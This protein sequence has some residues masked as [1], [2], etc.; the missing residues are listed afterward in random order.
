MIP[1]KETELY[2]VGTIYR[3]KKILI[4]LPDGGRAVMKHKTL[5]VIFE[6]KRTKDKVEFRLTGKGNYYIKHMLLKEEQ[7]HEADV[8]EEFE[9]LVGKG[10]D[11]LQVCECRL[12]FEM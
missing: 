7:V 5:F 9:R 4:E 11:L 3:E 8:V 12:I 10:K 6:H 2:K 1:V